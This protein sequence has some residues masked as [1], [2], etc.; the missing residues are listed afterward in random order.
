[1]VFHAEEKTLEYLPGI[2]KGSGRAPLKV[3]N[4]PISLLITLGMLS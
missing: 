3:G 1:M 4:F 2:E